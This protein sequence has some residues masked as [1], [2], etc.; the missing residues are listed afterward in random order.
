MYIINL[1]TNNF[2]LYIT[3]INNLFLTNLCT[4]WTKQKYLTQKNTEKTKT[5]SNSDEI[6]RSI[7]QPIVDQAAGDSKGY[8]K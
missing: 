7:I 3:C 8:V 1:D 4:I 5:N 6:A 2:Y